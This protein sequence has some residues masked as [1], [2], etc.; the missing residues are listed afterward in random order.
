MNEPGFF[1]TPANWVAIAYV[2]FFLLVGRK[3]WAVIAGMLDAR[4]NEIRAELYEAKRLRE[5]AE[6]LLRDASARRVAAI[7]EANALLEGAR[8]EALRL[9]AAAEADASA[10]AARR[11]RMALDRIAAAEKSAVD[12]VR[13]AAAEIAAIAAE[14]VI[15]EDLTE[16]AD[17]ALIDR[18]IGGL[19]AAMAR[20]AA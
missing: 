11:E 13:I 1:A 8:A 14:R 4:T 19:P 18:A 16:Q 17:A 9:A 20:R 10:A 2:T 7:S 15:R 6:A 12:E 3:L 5:E